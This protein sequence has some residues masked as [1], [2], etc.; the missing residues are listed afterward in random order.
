MWFEDSRSLHAST[1]VGRGR[2]VRSCKRTAYVDSR[3][4]VVG[5][6]PSYETL[7]VNMSYPP[8]PSFSFT[9]IRT[10]HVPSFNHSPSTHACTLLP[11]VGSSAR[12]LG[13][14]Q[15]PD[16]VRG[17]A[18]GGGF[19]VSRLARALSRFQVRIYVPCVHFLSAPW[20]SLPV[21]TF[22]SSSS[23]GG[24]CPGECLL[25]DE[26]LEFDYNMRHAMKSSRG[27]G[28]EEFGSRSNKIPVIF[29]FFFR[30]VWE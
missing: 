18:R 2:V 30:G 16:G 20:C 5:F 17:R 21:P 6:S 24:P 28:E 8:P 22:W 23:V 9:R 15:V 29:C 26:V 10:R 1:L 27:T 3:K 14:R 11:V 7:R 19:F 4:Y 12:P 25:H 13:L